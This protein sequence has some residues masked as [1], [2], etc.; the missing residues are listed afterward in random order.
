[1]KKYKK[2][3][4]IEGKKKNFKKNFTPSDP[5]QRRMKKYKKNKKKNFAQKKTKKIR[6]HKC[7]TPPEIAPRNCTLINSSFGTLYRPPI[8][9]PPIRAPKNSPNSGRSK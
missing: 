1:M 3:K 2:N 4:K 6:A 9:D 8:L 5:P 7:D